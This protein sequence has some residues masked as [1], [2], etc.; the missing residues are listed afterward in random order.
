MKQQSNAFDWEKN[1]VW[2]YSQAEAILRK[3]EQ[4]LPDEGKDVM[5]YL[6]RKQSGVVEVKWKK[7]SKKELIAKYRKFINDQAT[8]KGRKEL[9]ERLFELRTPG[10]DYFLPSLRNI[11]GLFTKEDLQKGLPIGIYGGV[12][13][14]QGMPDS[15]PSGLQQAETSPRL[16][17]ISVGNDYI[18]W[19]AVQKSL[20]PEFGSL[21]PSGLASG[22]EFALGQ[23]PLPGDHPARRLGF[24]NMQIS[25]GP[26]VDP[27][28][29]ML[30]PVH[31]IN[32]ARGPDEEPGANENFINVDHIWV[33]FP[34]ELPKLLLFTTQEVKAGDQLLMNYGPLYWDEN[35]DQ[36]LGK[37]PKIALDQIDQQKANPFSPYNQ[38][39]KLYPDLN[40]S[41]PVL[42]TEFFGIST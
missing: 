31:C 38:P 5:Y 33:K 2:A 7:C 25:I 27:E 16:G 23:V 18:R 12:F 19:Y 13:F 21:M 4:G 10:S 1:G 11:R 28:N 17:K 22:Y 24:E 29:K 8:P 3:S 20:N 35:S 9:Y 37:L 39:R 41:N 15:E 34:G 40:S 14:N 30:S 42:D 32:S 26:I 36:K 6:S